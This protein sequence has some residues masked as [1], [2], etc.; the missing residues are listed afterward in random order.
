MT[1]TISRKKKMK[2]EEKNSKKI[3]ISFLVYGLLG[4]L[5]LGSDK[6]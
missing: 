5:V 3:V 2:C 4:V 1:C 6:N